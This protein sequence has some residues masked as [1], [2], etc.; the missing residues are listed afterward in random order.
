MSDKTELLPCPFCGPK[1]DEGSRV[2]LLA[3][4]ESDGYVRGYTVRCDH[5]GIELHDEYESDVV[6]AWNRR[7]SVQEAA[8]PPSPAYLSDAQLDALAIC[9]HRTREDAVAAP[10]TAADVATALEHVRQFLVDG[11]DIPDDRLIYADVEVG[12]ENDDPSPLTIGDLRALLTLSAAPTAQGQDSDDTIKKR[13]IIIREPGSVPV[14]KIPKQSH[15]GALEFL[16]ECTAIYPAAELTLAELTWNNDLW[17][18]DG[19]EALTIDDAMA[20][21]A[22][23]ADGWTDRVPEPQTSGCEFTMSY[24]DEPNSIV[25]R[26][27][28]MIDIDVFTEGFDEGDFFHPCPKCNADAYAAWKAEIGD[29]DDEADDALPSAPSAG[30]AK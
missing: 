10:A 2:V 1:A 27:G 17:V 30:E 29:D 13:W 24:A 3:E 11:D 21:Y 4:R 7:S 18:S 25:C 9:G 20:E 6:A 19:R 23:D 15:D 8:P 5:C 16:R 22:D 28:H 14:T 26:N 12:E